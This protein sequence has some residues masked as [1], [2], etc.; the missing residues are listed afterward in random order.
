M[1]IASKI[2]ELNART[3]E[4]KKTISFAKDDIRKNNALVRKLAT[5]IRKTNE[6]LGIGTEKIDPQ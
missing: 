4:L 5:Q 3:E 6:I 2:A 1:D